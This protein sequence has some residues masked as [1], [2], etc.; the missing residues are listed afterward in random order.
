[1]K[2]QAFQMCKRLDYMCK[3]LDYTVRRSIV[4]IY[5]GHILTPMFSPTSLLLSTVCCTDLA[6]SAIYKDVRLTGGRA[7]GHR[8]DAEDVAGVEAEE[9]D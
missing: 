2:C 3:R 9:R 4:L 5:I 7:G 8:E 6:I 1:M